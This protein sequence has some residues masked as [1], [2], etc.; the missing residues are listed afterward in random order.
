ML[1]L[2]DDECAPLFA[3]AD[4]L[5][6]SLHDNQ[7]SFV[8]NRNV[9]YTNVCRLDCAFCAYHSKVGDEPFLLKP[10]DIVEKVSGLDI[11]EVSI[12]GGLHAQLRLADVCT[13]LKNIKCAHPD[14]HVHGF[15]PMEIIDFACKEGSS[16]EDVLGVLMNAGLDSLC[17]TAAEILD[18]EIRRIICK[19]KLT[20]Q[21]WCVTMRTAHRLGLSSTATMLFGHIE[22]EEHIARHMYLVREIQKETQGFSEFIPLPF[23]PYN[24]RLGSDYNLDFVGLRMTRKIIAC[25]R[26][27]FYGFINNIQTSWP[28]LGIDGALSCL[29]VGANDFGGTLYE[30]N[31][32]RSAG[33]EHGEFLSRETFTALI[34]SIGKKPIIRDTLYSFQNKEVAV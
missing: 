25:A 28:K 29:N 3:L 1:R 5:N 16:V 17:G 30:E 11:S 19:D 20:S 13:M 32:T 15:S 2:H 18:D 4:H 12:Q 26:I 9:N 31:I 21:A 27:F 24:T 10:R 6:L 7:V 23:I 8:L 22:T 34:E 33:G 14:I